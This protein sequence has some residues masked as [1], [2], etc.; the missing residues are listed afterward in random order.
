[1]IAF[2]KCF[3]APFHY[4]ANFLSDSVLLESACTLNGSAPVRCSQR[5]YELRVPMYHYIGV[6]GNNDDLAFLLY[7]AQTTDQ[8]VVNKSIVKIVFGLIQNDRF[9]PVSKYKCQ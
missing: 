3:T 5:E 4:R 2:F 9:R 1:M 8:Q 7:L 6:M